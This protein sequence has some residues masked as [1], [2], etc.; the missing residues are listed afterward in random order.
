MPSVLGVSRSFGVSSASP[1][2]GAASVNK[3]MRSSGVRSSPLAG[4]SVLLRVREREVNSRRLLASA[5]SSSPFEIAGAGIVPLCR[6]DAEMLSCR[7]RPG[8]APAAGFITGFRVSSPKNTAKQTAAGETSVPPSLVIESRFR[9][10]PG[11]SVGQ[12]P[13]VQEVIHLAVQMLKGGR[14]IQHMISPNGLFSQGQLRLFACLHLC[15]TPT[16][17]PG[18]ALQAHGPRRLDKHQTITNLI[19][20]RLHHDRRIQDDQWN[21]GIIACFLYLG[22]D[23]LANPRMRDRLQRFAL[24]RVGEDDG[25]QAASID[26]A[27]FIHDA[28]APTGDD[29][30]PDVGVAQGGLS[31]LIAR[32]DACSV[33]RESRRH[34]ALAA[35]DAAEQAD[36]QLRVRRS[37]FGVRSNHRRLTLLMSWNR[38]PIPL[39]R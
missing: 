1:S 20:P 29:T 14:V 39:A 18:H 5:M 8:E 17:L 30:G 33:T 9:F 35:A 22:V 24:L 31:Q 19:P 32:D 3:D 15:F 26:R 21:M 27:V 2:S 34:L 11:A 25:G 6:P 37:A 4:K 23:P 12:S 28:L 10:A 36:H 7:V 13:E 16:A 38:P